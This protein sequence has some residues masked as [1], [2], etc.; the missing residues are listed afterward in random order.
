MSPPVVGVLDLAPL[1]CVHDDDMSATSAKGLRALCAR[2][3][4]ERGNGPLWCKLLKSVPSGCVPSRRRGPQRVLRDRIRLPSAS[5]RLD[6]LGRKFWAICRSVPPASSVSRLRR[7]P[8]NACAFKPPPTAVEEMAG[9]DCLHPS[10]TGGDGCRRGRLTEGES[11]VF[12]LAAR[13]RN[14]PAAH[15]CGAEAKQDERH[16]QHASQA[17]RARRGVGQ[18]C[19]TI[20]FG[21]DF[22]RKIFATLLDRRPTQALENRHGRLQIARQ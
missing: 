17:K 1:A 19:R 8:M 22:T 6:E 18:L 15:T 5:V 14:A 21:P 3:R 10:K 11:N 2:G 4:V 13:A 7:A 16:D 12:D 20:F 9:C